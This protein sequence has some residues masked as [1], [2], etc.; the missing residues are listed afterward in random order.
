[1]ISDE[2]YLSNNFW[3]DND[4]S[5]YGK[6]TSQCSLMYSIFFL[7]KASTMKHPNK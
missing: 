4:L 2:L 5:L 3:K 7:V 1:M 6:M